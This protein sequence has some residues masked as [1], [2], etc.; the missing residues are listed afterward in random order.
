MY[1][2]LHIG[3]DIRVRQDLNSYFSP[4]RIVR[5][6]ACHVNITISGADIYIS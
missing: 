6:S 3:I 1:G 2:F 4:I 5:Q